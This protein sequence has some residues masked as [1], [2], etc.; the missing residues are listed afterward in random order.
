MIE[1]HRKDGNPIY[2]NIDSIESVFYD[3]KGT[4]LTTIFLASD[5]AISCVDETPKSILMKI[6]SARLERIGRANETVYV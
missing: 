6:K 1:V 3:I 2:V 5:N 4:G